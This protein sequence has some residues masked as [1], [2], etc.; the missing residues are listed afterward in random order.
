MNDVYQLTREIMAEKVTP[1]EKPI[2]E[3]IRLYPGT[4]LRVT[5]GPHGWG[6]LPDVDYCTVKIDGLIYNILAK[7]LK[8]S[9]EPIADKIQQ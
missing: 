5:C 9:A 3:A 1:E 7:V 2:G 4:V 8:A 6:V